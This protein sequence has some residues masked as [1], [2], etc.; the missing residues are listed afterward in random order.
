MYVCQSRS[1]STFGFSLTLFYL[2][3][4]D[5]ILFELSLHRYTIVR[6]AWAQDHL[7]LVRHVLSELGRAAGEA[8]RRTRSGLFVQKGVEEVRDGTIIDGFP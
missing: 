6:V 7:L 3:C 8:R 1:N 5:Q 2:F 4:V